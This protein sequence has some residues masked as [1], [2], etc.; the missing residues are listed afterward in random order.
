M[1]KWH[2]YLFITFALMLIYFICVTLLFL[3]FY[4]LISYHLISF[5]LIT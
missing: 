1:S 2:V 5:I 4:F 3:I